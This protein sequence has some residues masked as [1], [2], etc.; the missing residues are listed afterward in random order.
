MPGTPVDGPWTGTRARCGGPG[1]CAQCSK[2]SVTFLMSELTPAVSG[3]AEYH[4]ENTT[5]KVLQA[6]R[7]KGVDVD[8]ALEVMQE[9][10]AHGIVFRETRKRE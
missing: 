6:F 1:T 9:M 3:L 5:I 8:F 7:A 2:E 10:T 4:D